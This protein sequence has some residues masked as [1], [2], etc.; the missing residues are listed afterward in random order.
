MLYNIL[1]LVWPQVYDFIPYDAI[2]DIK[3]SDVF[4]LYSTSI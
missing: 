3:D 2:K 4:Q 1:L